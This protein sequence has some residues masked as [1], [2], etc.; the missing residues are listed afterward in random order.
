MSGAKKAADKAAPETAEAA[1]SEL[2][3]PVAEA[4]PVT[5][6]YVDAAVAKAFAEATKRSAAQIDAL[7]EGMAQLRESFT[8]A[9]DQVSARVD[10][11]SAAPAMPASISR[12][13][14][15]IRAVLA[16]I[17]G[18]LKRQ[19]LLTPPAT[20]A[21]VEAALKVGCTLHVLQAY[22]AMGIAFEAG[23]RLESTAFDHRS[24]LDGVRSGKLLV[25]IVSSKD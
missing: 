13:L 4:A 2:T 12:E 11:L 15:D 22:K 23:R 5:M 19:D 24:I 3:A 8:A 25:S 20:A 7:R 9:L 1:V 17:G 10:S 18:A 6:A 14:D 16:R 21:Q